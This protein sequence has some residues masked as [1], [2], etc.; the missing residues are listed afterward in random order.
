M[1]WWAA[2]AQGLSSVAGGTVGY[3]S[4]RDTNK[5]NYKIWQE[6]QD[7]AKKMQDRQN[8]ETWK[9]WNAENAYNTP[10]NQ[11]KLWEEAGFS[12]Y[13][14]LGTDTT[15]GSMS[16]AVG[17]NPTAP[18]MQSPLSAFVDPVTQLFDSSIRAI[19]SYKN[20]KKTDEEIRREK[21]AADDAETTALLNKVNFGYNSTKAQHEARTAEYHADIEMYN[22]DIA[23]RTRNSTV[24][25]VDANAKKAEREADLVDAQLAWQKLDNRQKQIMVDTFGIQRS[26]EL[27][28]AFV[29]LANKKKL[30]QLTDKQIQLELSRIIN[31]GKKGKLLDEQIEGQDI[32]NQS[33]QVA[34]DTQK[35]EYNAK[36]G[37]T[38]EEV[39]QTLETMWEINCANLGIDK[40]VANGIWNAAKRSAD[41]DNYEGAYDDAY[42]KKVLPTATQTKGE[43]NVEGKLPFGIGKYNYK[44][45][46][47]Y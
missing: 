40:E 35:N 47:G 24:R 46:R 15:A 13:A 31:E 37:D 28:T 44:A 12:P 9:M 11:R 33:A 8:A 23:A 3:F 25:T 6:S 41:N 42:Y 38:P 27:S 45:G 14:A 43:L 18:V 34:L 17:A 30:G 36:F 4:Q 29:E 1:A 21:A 10:E 32:A 7:F 5:Q 22:R 20:L 2:L 19:Q 39:S 26:L 16:S